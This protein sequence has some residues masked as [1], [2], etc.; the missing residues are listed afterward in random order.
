MTSPYRYV[1]EATKDGESLLSL[2][3]GI[4][5]ELTHLKKT[6]DVTAVDIVPQYLAEVHKRC[7]QAKVVCSDAL[8]YV[9][10]QLDNSVD[11]ISLIDGIE[12]MAKEVGADLISEMKRVCRKKILIFTTEGYVRNEPHNAW[13]IEGANE[14]QVH[15]SGWRIEE[16]KRYD[17]NL[18]SREPGITQHGEPYFALMFVYEK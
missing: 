2:C 5:L 3:S 4:G 14:Y 15:K 9:K 1:R 6:C 16:L 10:G 13:G 17:F 18:I 12:H 8:T 7:L 11:V